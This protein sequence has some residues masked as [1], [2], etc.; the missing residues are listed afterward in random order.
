M[1]LLQI[2][3]KEIKKCVKCGACRAHCPVFEQLRREPSVARGKVALARAILAGDIKLDY[4]T[5]ADMSRCLLCGSCVEKC[6]NNVPTDQVVMAARQ[7]LA[8]KR[9]LTSFHKAI[10]IVL[11]NRG[12]M[13]AGAFAAVL[14]NPLIF[15]RVPGSS[16]LRLRFPLP[17]IARNRHFPGITSKPFL[18]R[19][20]EVI[21]GQPGKPKILYFVGCMTNFV[22][23][24]IGE[25][26]LRLLIKLG[27]TVIIPKE[28]ECCGF[29]AMS[30][31]DTDTLS[32]L[33][34]RNFAAFEKHRA[35]FIMTACASCGSALQEFYPAV[36]AKMKPELAERCQAT[37]DK[38]VD[39]AVLL[40]NL[41]FKPENAIVGRKTVITYHDPCHLRR[42]KITGEPR[43]LLSSLPRAEYVEME[44]AASCCGLGGTFNA[45]H[46]DVSLAINQPKCDSIRK[47]GAEIVVTG[48]PG[49]MIQISDGLQQ[50]GM[51]TRVAHTLEM[52]DGSW[53]YRT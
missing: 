10:R 14:L 23:P 5:Y 52:L 29:P 49:C 30:G 27:C 22:Y 9:G 25:A 31:G 32:V 47:S 8:R 20:P 7:A 44:N 3:E 26:A 45:Y 28:Q 24:E 40:Q 53:K 37:A 13:N 42:R 4:R 51:K 21:P 6:P 43:Q 35:D 33:A 50:R 36:L 41:G 15:R 34:E 2:I 46:Y 19:H 1:D 18:R 16:G 17:F 38:I 12:I 39:A 48:C 11:K